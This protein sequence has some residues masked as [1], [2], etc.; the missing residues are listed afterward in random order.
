MAAIFDDKHKGKSYADEKTNGHDAKI[1]VDELSGPVFCGI[2]SEADAAESEQ[3]EKQHDDPGEAVHPLGKENIGE[4]NSD[5]NEYG[6]D[7]Y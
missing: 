1:D 2:L 7:V 6:V 5:S 4:Q 3:K